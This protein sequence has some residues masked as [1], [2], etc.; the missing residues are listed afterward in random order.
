MLEATN[1][2][3][4]S[5]TQSDIAADLDAFSN[6]PWLISAYMVRSLITNEHCQQPLIFV[7]VDFRR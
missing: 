5:T 3:T 6:T 7:V 4:I 2:T 1:I